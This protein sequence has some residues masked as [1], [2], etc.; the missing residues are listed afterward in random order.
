MRAMTI[1]A[2]V[3]FGLCAVFLLF[4]S[5]VDVTRAWTVVLHN[6]YGFSY[7]KQGDP[8][9]PGVP[10]FLLAIRATVPLIVSVGAVLLTAQYV[11]SASKSRT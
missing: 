6:P 10:Y 2:W 4:A 7:L 8:T 1:A 3:I 11:F 9:S 5:V